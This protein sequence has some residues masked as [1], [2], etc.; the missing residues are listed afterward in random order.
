[1]LDPF[2]NAANGTRP[3]EPY[4]HITFA[5]ATGEPIISKIRRRNSTSNS[6]DC[7]F[8]DRGSNPEPPSSIWDAA[9]A[10]TPIR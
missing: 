3:S 10:R 1:M 6:P 8:S 4:E 9:P 5:A 7:G 2:I